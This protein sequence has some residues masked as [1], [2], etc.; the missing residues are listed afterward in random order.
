LNEENFQNAHEH[1]GKQLRFWTHISWKYAQN[2]LHTSQSENFHIS[3]ELHGKQLNFWTKNREY[4]PRTFSAKL[5]G[6]ELS[7]S[8]WTS[9]Q[10]A[11]FLDAKVVVM[12]PEL[13][14]KPRKVKTSEMRLNFV[15]NSFIF[16]RINRENAPWTFT[17]NLAGRELLKCAWTS[18]QHLRFRTQKSRKCAQK[19]FCEPWMG[20]TSK[21]CLN[22]TACSFSIGRKS[23]KY[24]HNFLHKACTEKT[25]K[26]RLNFAANSFVFGHI[27]RGNAPRI[28]CKPC[29]RRTSEMRL[30]FS[31]NSFIFGRK[32]EKMRH[33]FL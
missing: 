3:S 27:N 5:A 15:G 20:R 19:F 16:G 33:I 32:I 11:S 2:F 22:W 13:F 23:W 7:K 30:N 12:C 4:A 1:H 21:A 14:Y 10:I 9:R 31:A 17:I 24:A 29:K 18:P 6:E 28:F 25:S 26:I 8:V